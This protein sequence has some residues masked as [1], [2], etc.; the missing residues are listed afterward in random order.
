M[1]GVIVSDADGEVDEEEGEEYGGEADADGGVDAAVGQGG[2]AAG[3]GEDVGA[4]SRRVE[5][6][7]GA[8][9]MRGKRVLSR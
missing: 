3:G 2:A 5:Q 6:A 7:G 1:I 4:H 8:L 9:R